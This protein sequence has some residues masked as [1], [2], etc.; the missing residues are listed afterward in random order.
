MTVKNIF[1]SVSL[2]QVTSTVES[3]TSGPL[4]SL[5]LIDSLPTQELSS[6]TVISYSPDPILSRRAAVPI[7]P[8]PAPKSAQL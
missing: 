1:P 7:T 5:I 3:S 2:L 6:V 4:T 8:G